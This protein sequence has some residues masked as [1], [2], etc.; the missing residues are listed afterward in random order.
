MLGVIGLAF[1][2]HEV[3]VC[4]KKARQTIAN[5]H[6]LQLKKNH[7]IA[8]NRNENAL[9]HKAIDEALGIH[10]NDDNQPRRIAVQLRN[11]NGE[12]NILAVTTQLQIQKFEEKKHNLPVKKAHYTARI[13]NRKNV[14]VTL[15]DPEQFNNRS[16]EMLEELFALTPA[17]AALADCLA[18]DHSLQEAADI[19]GRK[20]G[21][22]RIQLQ[23]I[24]EKTD[25]N[26]QASLIKLIMSIP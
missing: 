16:C 24:F 14:L 6:V 15:C 9:L 12:K 18:D 2:L 20:A 26:R 5:S 13:P 1:T 25:T 4:N 10:N 21:T 22:A 19:L 23:S 3:V 7:L 8:H 11:N 17:E